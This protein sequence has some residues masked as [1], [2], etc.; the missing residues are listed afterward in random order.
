M[1]YGGDNTTVIILVGSI[2]TESFLYLLTTVL[3]KA[4]T[5]VNDT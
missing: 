1:G 5:K 3:L 2:A 4:Y